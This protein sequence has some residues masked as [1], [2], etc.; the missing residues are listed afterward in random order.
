[1]LLPAL[2]PDRSAAQQFN[3]NDFNTPEATPSRKATGCGAD[4][5][6]SIRRI[7]RNCLTPLRAEIANLLD[8]FW[9]QSGPRGFLCGR[10]VSI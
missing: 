6:L 3:S 9:E 10:R 5:E 4:L 1:M 2:L 7:G 8:A